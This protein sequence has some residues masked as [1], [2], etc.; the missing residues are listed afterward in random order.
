MAIEIG[1]QIIGIAQRSVRY[2]DQGAPTTLYIRDVTFQVVGM[3][4]EVA[5]PVFAIAVTDATQW[6][7]LQVGATVTVSITP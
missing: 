1:A 4:E 7:Q 2:Q 5:P 3:P 6:D